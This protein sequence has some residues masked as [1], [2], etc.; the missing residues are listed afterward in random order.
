MPVLIQGLLISATPGDWWFEDDSPH[1]VFVRDH[2]NPI[3]YFGPE[4]VSKLSLNNSVTPWFTFT[5]WIDTLFHPTSTAPA[6]WHSLF[7]FW[8]TACLLFLVLRRLM[9]EGIALA[10]VLLWPF[11]PSSIVTLEFLSTRHYLE[12]LAFSL[13]AVLFCLKAVEEEGKQI[14]MWTA[15]AFYLLAC[16][17]KEVYVSGT[18]FVL[19][20]F[21]LKARRFG[22]AVGVFGC[23]LL[24]AGYRFLSL[25]AG[26]K[27]MDMSFLS[28]YD[29]FL[30]RYPFMFGGNNGGYLL[31]A[32]TFGLLVAAL[33]LRRLSFQQIFFI[34]GTLGVMLFTIVPVTAPVTHGYEG[35]GPWYRVLFLLNT[36]ILAVT[37]YLAGKV[38]P[39]RWMP[40]PAVIFAA[41]LG[42]GAW[43]AAEAWDAR[44]EGYT[45]D[46]RFYLAHPDRLLYSKE[47]APWF[48]YGLHRLYRPGEVAHY[49]TWRVDNGTPKEHVLKLLDA[50]PE[51][52]ARD[53]DGVYRIQP[54]LPAIIR[55]NCERGAT[56][57]HRPLPEKGAP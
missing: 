2:P 4:L 40:V 20:C 12:G 54:G 50:Y 13:A 24:Y 35:L 30:T 25:G 49:L 23:G 34:G 39:L 41:V 43:N 3:A 53:D 37:A 47:P 9:D 46:G 45:L 14:Y 11:L 15:S 29:L 31:A 22:A 1:R 18:F 6:Y 28:Q 10:T 17:A 7:S 42:L 36:Y 26:G 38:L 33:A 55:A 32:V 57:L 5:F 44:K 52:W 27:P 16:T 56:P 19:I 51:I 8:V 48:L 21:Y